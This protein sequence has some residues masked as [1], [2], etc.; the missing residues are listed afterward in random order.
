MLDGIYRNRKFCQVKDLLWQG[1]SFCVLSS[2]VAWSDY[3]EFCNHMVFGQLSSSVYENSKNLIKLSGY[4]C[5]G[6]ALLITNNNSHCLCQHNCSSYAQNF[7]PLPLFTS[8]RNNN[9]IHFNLSYSHIKKL[10]SRK[11]IHNGGKTKLKTYK[12]NL[13]KHMVIN[14]LKFEE[15]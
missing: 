6:S 1:G 3:T 4:F 14:H 10:L 11:L 2:F 8:H 5:S 9:T 15:Q 7:T 12:L 13:N